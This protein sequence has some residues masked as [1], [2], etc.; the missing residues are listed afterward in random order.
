MQALNSHVSGVS[1]KQ[2]FL[3]GYSDEVKYRYN[4]LE[5]WQKLKA[6][7]CE[8]EL[9]FKAINVSKAT[10][11]R[12]QRLYQ[13]EGLAGLESLSRKPHKIRVAAEQNRIV[14]YVLKL[15]K[16]YPLFGKEKIKI[17]LFEEYGIRASVSTIGLVI[18]NLIKSGKIKHSYDICGKRI[19]SKWRQFD[20]HAKRL[21]FGLKAEK[22][23]ELIQ[24]D[25]MAVGRYKHFAAVCP[26]SK[27]VFSYAYKV[28]TSFAG[29]D[30]LQKAVLFFPFK[31]SSIQVDGGG[32]FMA[33]FENLCQKMG[34][35]LYVLPPRS[36]KINGCV[37]RSNGTMRYEFYALH[38][39]FEILSDLNE[40]LVDFT[41]FYN[42]KRPHQRL[43][44][45]TPLRYLES[46]RVKNS[47]I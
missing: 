35:S 41:R 44:Y 46:R 3:N 31:I 9:I 30:F 22:L 18:S 38:P 11:F 45:M 1:V 21:P 24:I 34:I 26:I 37:E 27:L 17:F 7:Q 29:A 6:E 12:W 15:R 28:A 47:M 39:Q 16:K 36:P 10:L 14:S 43:N 13:E 25:H 20:N 32:E 8:N 42:E 33:E 19:R 40:K 23:G 5:I 4:K 2:N